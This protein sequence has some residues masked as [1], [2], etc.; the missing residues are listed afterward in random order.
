MATTLSAQPISTAEVAVTR[1]AIPDS[2]PWHIWALFAA[3]VSVVIG[4]YWDI[5]W[6]MSIGRDTF[7]TPAHLMIQSGGLIAGLS[8]GDRVVSL[9]AHLLQEGARVRIA[10]ESSN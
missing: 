6:H 9:G 5:S 7:W 10:S 2:V 3:S 1:P 8:S 4:G